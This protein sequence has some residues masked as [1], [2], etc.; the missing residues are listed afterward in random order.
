MA[1]SLYSSL[2]W[3]LRDKRNLNKIHFWP[4]SLGAISEYWYI[5]RGQTLVSLLDG[6]FYG[7]AMFIGNSQKEVRYLAFPVFIAV[8]F[9]SIKITADILTTFAG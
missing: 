4:E 8:R 2:F 9:I 6:L 5:E 3:E 1:F 7:H